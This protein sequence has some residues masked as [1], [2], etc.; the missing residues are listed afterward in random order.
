MGKEKR[1]G[2]EEGRRKEGGKFQ[3]ACQK[4]ENLSTDSLLEVSSMAKGGWEKCSNS[5]PQPRPTSVEGGIANT[6]EFINSQYI[7]FVLIGT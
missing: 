3:E 2:E 4:W 7:L 6:S 1:T 5:F